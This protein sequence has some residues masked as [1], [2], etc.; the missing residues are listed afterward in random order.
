[1]ALKLTLVYSISTL[2][3]TSNSLKNVACLYI[4]TLTPFAW[5]PCCNQ[6][7]MEQKVAADM[8]YDMCYDNNTSKHCS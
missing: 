8:M 1:M 4:T 7:T 6:R 5:T 3:V 2:T